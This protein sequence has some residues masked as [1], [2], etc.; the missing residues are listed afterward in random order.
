M[1]FLGGFLGYL[2]GL[3]TRRVLEDP[4]QV[5]KQ[6]VAGGWS[7]YPLVSVYVTTSMENNNF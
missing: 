2:G 1:A 3:A 4:M 6:P 7:M 5:G